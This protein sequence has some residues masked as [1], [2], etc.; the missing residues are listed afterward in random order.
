V[1]IKFFSPIQLG[2]QAEYEF[3]FGSKSV[4]THEDIHMGE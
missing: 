3:F 1:R 2:K 4:G